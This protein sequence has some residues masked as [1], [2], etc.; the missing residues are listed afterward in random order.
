MLKL[1]LL[2]EK[3][4]N[5]GMMCELTLY[6]RR[7]SSRFHG[8]KF[9]E[10]YNCHPNSIEENKILQ[11]VIIMASLSSLLFCFKLNKQTMAIMNKTVMRNCY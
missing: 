2:M 3:L 11:V 7:L 10:D 8:G 6:T 5:I 9:V 1:E 4:D